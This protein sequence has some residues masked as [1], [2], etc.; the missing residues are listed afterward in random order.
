MRARMNETRRPGLLH[1]FSP[2]F[3][4]SCFVAT[5]CASTR[6]SRPRA[7]EGNQPV[8]RPLDVYRRLGFMAGPP[9]FPAVARIATLAGPADSTYL[10]LSFSMP[11]SALRFQRGSTGFYAEYRVQ[12]SV[13][14][15]SLEIKKL[16]KRETVQVS[17][18]QETTRE[19]E[20]I[21]F[22]DF[23][24]VQP[25]TYT[26]RLQAND[27]NSS[28]G[29][30]ASD[31]IK[32]PAHPAE[33]RLSGPLLVF[34][35][36]GR[37]DVAQRPD[38]IVNPRGTVAYGGDAPRVYLELYGATQPELVRVRVRDEGDATLWAGEAKMDEGT[39]AL[40]YSIVEIPAGALP[41]GRVWIEAFEAT[42]TTQTQRMPLLVTISD[43]WVV[44]NFDEM[45]EFVRYIAYPSEIDSLRSSSNIERNQLW[46][47][48]WARRDP[49]PGLPGN[50]FRD[51]FFQRVRT[52]VEEFPEPGVPGW[53]TERGEV[54]IVLGAPAYINE[55]YI[56]GSTTPRPNVVEWLYQDSPGGPIVLQFLD[57]TGFGRF[58]LSQGSKVT[59]MSAAH[60]LRPK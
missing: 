48:F 58:E 14:R 1:S 7:T 6:E 11:N 9:E 25:G 28:R 60:R 59:F 19:E 56:G 30:R 23:I 45:L 33:R 41:I 12:A 34:Q 55:R 8:A 31:T 43:Q 24:A 47:R 49:Y 5:A 29:F 27:L 22:Q 17:N 18:F 50:E 54:Y 53:K 51:Q 57:R 46:E 15:D 42:D 3:V 37:H 2:L 35:G 4:L 20:S 39:T 13:M 36:A 52:A 32:A 26:V 40:R 38:L 44:A 10:L 21:I 16:D